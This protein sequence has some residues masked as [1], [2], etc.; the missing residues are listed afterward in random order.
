MLAMIFQK[1]NICMER[2]NAEAGP[3]LKAW[4]MFSFE[5]GALNILVGTIV[6]FANKSNK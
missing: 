1:H 2:N 5:T 6:F 4:N 3:D